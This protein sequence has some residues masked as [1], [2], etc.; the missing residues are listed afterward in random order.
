MVLAATYG[1]RDSG[2]ESKTVSFCATLRGLM[3]T[4]FTC[5]R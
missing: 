2:E 5:T 1:A 4:L 3:T